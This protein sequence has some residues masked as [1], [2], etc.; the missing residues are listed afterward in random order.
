MF[1]M[2]LGIGPKCVILND[3]TRGVD[4]AAKAEIHKFVLDLP[5]NGTSVL[6]FTAELPELMS[7]CRPGD[8]LACRL[9]FWRSGRRGDPGRAHHGACGGRISMNVPTTHVRGHARETNWGSYSIYIVCVF[10]F[11]LVALSRENFLRF[12]NL[13]S[14]VFGLS[15]EFL[16]I[17]ATTFLLIM[18]E[19]DLSIGSIFAFSGV[20]T[21]YLLENLSLPIWL[22]IPVALA[23]T[24]AVGLVNGLLVVR[25][26]A[27]SLMITIGTMILFRGIADGLIN[28]LGGITYSDEYR[29][30]A[31]IKAGGVHLTIFVMCV[32]IIVLEVLLVKHAGFRTLYYI[33]NNTRSALLYGVRVNRIKLTVFVLS[34][35]LP[36]WRESWQAPAAAK[37]SGILARAWSSK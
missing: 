27:N 20:F 25:L 12:P 32:V 30:I 29:A 13:Y 22:A 6:L 3:P 5:K 23:A 15:M 14:L 19:V 36:A 28:F 8:C 26:R 37:P 31:G 4:V 10:V 1:S 34:G 33:G 2:C 11:L 21:G 16:P 17:I 24:A 18:G 7:L 9:C 35:L